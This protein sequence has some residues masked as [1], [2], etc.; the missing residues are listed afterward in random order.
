MFRPPGER[1]RV[2]EVHFTGNQA[3]PTSQLANRLADVAIGAAY[4]DPALRL[5]LDTSI[6]P[7]YEARGLIR[8]S[9]TR[10]R[11]NSRS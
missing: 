1:A 6:R 9:C 2:A 5:L 7:L 8:V 3:I 10:S 11:T 4:T